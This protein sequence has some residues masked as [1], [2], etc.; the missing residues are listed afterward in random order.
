MKTLYCWFARDVTAAM[1]VSGQEQKHFAPPGTKLYFHV[2]SSKKNSIVLTP[3]MAA[4]HMVAIQE[5]NLFVFSPWFSPTY[6]DWR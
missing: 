2:N 5:Y 1:Y 3:N 4:C 6:C